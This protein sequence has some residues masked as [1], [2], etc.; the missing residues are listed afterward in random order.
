[1]DP[2]IARRQQLLDEVPTTLANVLLDRAAVFEKNIKHE[3]WLWFRVAMNLDE[4][5][6]CFALIAIDPGKREHVIARKPMGE[7]ILAAK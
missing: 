2:G 5:P 3:V 4:D 1:M 7:L 6:L